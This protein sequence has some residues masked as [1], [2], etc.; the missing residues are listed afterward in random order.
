MARPGP[1]MA[2]A[3]HTIAYSQTIEEIHKGVLKNIDEAYGLETAYGKTQKSFAD[4]FANTLSRAFILDDK[5]LNKLADLIETGVHDS[6]SLLV[7]LE[8]LNEVLK[9][10][11]EEMGEQAD[12]SLRD[13]RAE[14]EEK[15]RRSS[16]YA[17]EAFTG[18]VEEKAYLKERDSNKKAFSKDASAVIVKFTEFLDKE[19]DSDAYPLVP[20][21]EQFNAYAWGAL[22]SV[23]SHGHQ[24]LVDA[25]YG[26][27]FLL[28]K[29]DEF[30]VTFSNIGWYRQRFVNHW[31]SLA[32]EKPYYIDDDHYPYTVFMRTLVAA[33]GEDR[34][35]ETLEAAMKNFP[36]HNL[37]DVLEIVNLSGGAGTRE[38]SYPIVALQRLNEQK[39]QKLMN[40]LMNANSSVVDSLALAVI[41][42]AGGAESEAVLAAYESIAK[43]AETEYKEAGKRMAAE[44]AA[45]P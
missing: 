19:Y 18:S 7:S 20:P 12:R 8:Q 9:K 10:G 42:S 5:S 38:S 1:Q 22:A 14:F 23:A 25:F 17:N 32:K 13:K 39:V 15:K 35:I 4:D 40:R 26:L 33:N 44:R 16:T 28:T 45:N 29:Y 6:K 24:S 21:S 41:N 34:S 3:E 30:L 27:D 11:E 43:V 31:Q 2:G 36:R 37:L